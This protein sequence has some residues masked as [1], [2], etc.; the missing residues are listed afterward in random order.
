MPTKTPNDTLAEMVIRL[1]ALEQENA[2]LKSASKS[3]GPTLKLSEKGCISV[4]GLSRFPVSL[5]E[6]QWDALMTEAM[7]Q[8]FKDFKA[9]HRTE[10]DKVA[11][12]H[13]AGKVGKPVVQS[14]DSANK[15]VGGTATAPTPATGK[16]F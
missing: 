4:Y 5:Y 14:T 11:A 8:V 2:V 9:S 15:G 1:K 6:G 10:L 3:K 7:L 13:A 12:V 16:A